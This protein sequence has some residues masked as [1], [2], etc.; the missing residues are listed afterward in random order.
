MAAGQYDPVN[1]NSALTTLLG[2]LEVAGVSTG[3]RSSA[4]FHA[5]LC[6]VSRVVGM[7]LE[8]STHL[9]T[10]SDL[11]SAYTCGHTSQTVRRTARDIR[12]RDTERSTGPADR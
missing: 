8:V 2:A 10:F 4:G 7:T 5:L 3:E 9:I 11:L 1:H 12:H 6:L